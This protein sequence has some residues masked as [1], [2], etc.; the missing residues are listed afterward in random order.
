MSKHIGTSNITDLTLVLH[1][2]FKIDIAD[3]QALLAVPIALASLSFCPNDCQYVYKVK[4]QVTNADIWKCLLSQR[5]F[6][7]HLDIY[8]DAMAGPMAP[9]HGRKNSHL[10]LM[11]TFTNLK[12]LSVR[13]EVLLG[14]CCG[15]V[16]A[17][18]QLK[19][20]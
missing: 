8:R 7:R 12:T 3:L 13:W 9:Q 1:S 2:D 15:D 4:Q 16:K 20:T 18:F 5:I 19:D 10:G 14:E 6:F 11:S 17:P